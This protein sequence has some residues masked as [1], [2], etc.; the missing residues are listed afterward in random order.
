MNKILHLT[1]FNDSNKF[2]CIY[3]KQ[4]PKMLFLDKIEGSNIITKYYCSDCKENMAF[5]SSIDNPD[6]NWISYSC[7][8][9]FMCYLFRRH[10]SYIYIETERSASHLVGFDI[11]PK[12]IHFF[13][14]IFDC[15]TP[16]I[17]Y[18]KIK[19]ILTFT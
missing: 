8:K 14:K 2:N 19:T 13:P 1:D 15:Q 5:C 3:C 9:Y 18:N 17:L 10:H 11:S 16:E 7:K 12:L 4:K 6:D